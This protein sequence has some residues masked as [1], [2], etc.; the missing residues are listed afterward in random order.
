MSANNLDEKAKD[1]AEPRIEFRALR[2]EIDYD[3]RRI[4]SAGAR[5]LLAVAN[6]AAFGGLLSTYAREIAVAAC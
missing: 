1:S 4:Q 6:P 5:E 2:G 3:F